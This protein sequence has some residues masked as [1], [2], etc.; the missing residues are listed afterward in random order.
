MAPMPSANPMRN[1]NCWRKFF[2]RIQLRKERKKAKMSKPNVSSRT[3]PLWGVS[4]GW[5]YW[6]RLDSFLQS[7]KKI[8]RVKILVIAK[9]IEVDPWCES[10]VAFVKVISINAFR[11]VANKKR[12]IKSISFKEFEFWSLTFVAADGFDT[13]GRLLNVKISRYRSHPWFI[14]LI[15][16]CLSYPDLVQVE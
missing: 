9:E 16:L 1:E 13:N 8:L 15:T 7:R 10:K 6:L 4:T 5:K 2:K 11:E 3:W 12:R 14:R